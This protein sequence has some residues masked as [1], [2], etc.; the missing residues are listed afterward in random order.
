[1][2]QYI[3]V[4]MYFK[5]LEAIL[6]LMNTFLKTIQ[7]MAEAVS[8]APLKICMVRHGNTSYLDEYRER[9]DADEAKGI[10]IATLTPEQRMQKTI[11]FNT[12]SMQAKF[13]D[14]YVTE[15]GKEVFIE[16]AEQLQAVKIHDIVFVSPFRRTI[17][18][19]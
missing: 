4:R 3:N 8:S 7:K 2:R 9:R 18:S 10:D 11:D 5:L 16:S 12:H 13:I 19:A 1:M 14:D 17:Q 15:S 6:Y